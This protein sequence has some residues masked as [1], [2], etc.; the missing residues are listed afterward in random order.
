[1]GPSVSNGETFRRIEE[2][3]GPHM[4]LQFFGLSGHKPRGCLSQVGIFQHI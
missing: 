2:Q 3:L 4:T 1:M